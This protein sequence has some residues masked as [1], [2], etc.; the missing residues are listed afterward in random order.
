M[1]AITRNRIFALPTLALLLSAVACTG[2]SPGEGASET[3]GTTDD[4]TS[5]TTDGTPGGV[6]PPPG[7]AVG[8][9]KPRNLAPD[10]TAEELAT[11]A[12]EERDFAVE[13]FKA[14]PAGEDNRAISPTSLRVAFGMLHEGARTVS[15]AEIADA[16]HFTLD[17]PRLHNAFNHIDLEFAARELP[18]SGEVE[19]DDSVQ[20]RLVNQVFGRLDVEWELPFLD[21]LAV[22]YG[23]DMHALDFRDDPEGS[24]KAINKWVAGETADRIDELLPPKSIFSTVTGVLVNALYLKAP[25]ERPFE[26]VQ[27][28]AKFTRKDA[29]E[30]EVAM[31]HGVFD[32]TSYFKGA[33]VEAAELPL[34]GSELSMVFILPEAGTFDAYVA[35]LDGAGL[36][37]VLAGL[38][39]QPLELGV[40]RFTFESAFGLKKAL[41]ALGM[42]KSFELGGGDFSGLSSI[43]MAIAD[44][45]HSTFLGVDEKGVEAAAATAIVLY[46]T[47]GGI[48]ADQSFTADRPFL[49]AIRDRGTDTLL[50]FGRV[51]DPSAP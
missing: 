23:S 41:Q 14:L 48:G 30:V 47:E 28:G 34:R 5:S 38:S 42:T 43:Q 4:P 36:G 25:W 19:G 13:L 40:P 49:F 8:S 37:E 26:Y 24:R 33:G 3:E 20:L 31:M 39:L 51:L 11:L 29:S 46:D 6:N 27:E 15:E 32:T 50:W 44:V 21:V 1:P 9:D 45:Y 17:K 7:E 22:H 12:A 10:A 16:L 2:T 18:T 35:G